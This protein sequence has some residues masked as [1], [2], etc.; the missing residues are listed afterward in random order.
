[1]KTDESCEGGQG[2]YVEMPV[3]MKHGDFTG[4]ADNYTKYRPDYSQI[5]LKCLFGLLNK[6]IESID[7]LDVGAGTG[8]WTRMVRDGGVRSVAAVEPNDDMRSAGENN[9]C[10]NDII[11]IK[12]KGD[13]IPLPD[14]SYDLATMASSFHWTDFER[15][16]REFAR[17]LR[18][19]GVFCALWNPR[20]IESNPILLD[21]EAKIS[22]LNPKVKRIS[23]GQSNHIN[24]LADDLRKSPYFSDVVYIEGRHVIRF[25]RQRYIGVWESVNDVK[26]QL[27]EEKWKMFMNYINERLVGV[28]SIDCEYQTRAWACINR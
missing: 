26:F 15:S 7:F 14:N 5:V 8:I 10:N 16:T 18:P 9:D 1:M 22:E 12:G 25:S 17:V 19:G 20:F 21:I 23:S 3:A 4:L 24:K 13:N 6:P 28:D 27:G 11:W 2:K